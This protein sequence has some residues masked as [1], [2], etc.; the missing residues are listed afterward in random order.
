MTIIIKH[1]AVKD[2]GSFDWPSEFFFCDDV[3]SRR[4]RRE[5][6]HHRA[7]GRPRLAHLQV[8]QLSARP[9]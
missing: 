4:L 6:C 5:I 1:E 7:S 8:R 3:V 2:T 9:V